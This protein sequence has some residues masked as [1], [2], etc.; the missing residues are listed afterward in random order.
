MRILVADD[1]QLARQRLC[2]LV[3]EISPD[4][5]IIAEAENGVQ[6]I[7]TCRTIQPDLVLLDIRMPGVNGIDAAHQLS[8]L[9]TPP[10]VIFTTA[11]DQHALQAFEAHAID[12][13]VKP[14]RKER[15]RTALSKA[16]MFIS[17]PPTKQ[18]I[19][20]T[21]DNSPRKRIGARVHGELMLISVD[22]ICFFRSEQKYTIVGTCMNEILIE[23]PLTAL[24]IEF[25]ERFIRIHRN[26]LVGIIFI[27]GLEKDG[28]GRTLIRLRGIDQHLEVSRRHI[29]KVR[30]LMKKFV[31]LKGFSFYNNL[32]E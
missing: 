5:V 16:K 4:S 19:I 13:L 29:P 11:Y 14:I 32:L 30:A 10:A 21:S 1:E 15:L 22:E 26:A 9:D 27:Q 6:V 20:P 28:A 31:R 2:R 8:L 7:H 3:Q 12:Y 24:E 25:R 23:E 18:N 17:S